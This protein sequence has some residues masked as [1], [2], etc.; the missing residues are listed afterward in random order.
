VNDGVVRK[1]DRNEKL[2]RY[3]VLEDAYGNRFTYA[4]LGSVA[5]VYPVPKREKLSTEDF[6]LVRPSNEKQPAQ[7]AS[8]GTHERKRAKTQAASTDS[9]GP[10]NTEDSRER[11]YAFP[12]REANLGRAD[13]TGQL[14]E[15]LARRFPGYEGFKAAFSGILR[16]D[17]Q[18]M[19]MEALH[20]GS[21]VVA[22]SCS[23]PPPST[24]RPARTRSATRAPRSARSS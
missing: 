17:R 1:I 12:E 14:D 24:A 21:K 13:L 3:L 9:S 10:V 23:R 8:A 15:L 16:F 11:L 2:G 20:E 19:E 22:G 4:Q 18:T 6:E 5:E 7:P